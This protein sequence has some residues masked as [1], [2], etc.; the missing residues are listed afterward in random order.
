MLTTTSALRKDKR[1]RAQL[2][3]RHF[4]FIAEVLSRLNTQTGYDREFL[5]DHF[6]D[7]CATTNPRFD[8]Q[9]FLNAVRG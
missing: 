5:A 1:T 2:Q 8:R 3:H 6:A 9:R 7:A 4:A